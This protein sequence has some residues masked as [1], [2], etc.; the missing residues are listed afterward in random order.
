MWVKFVFSFLGGYQLH[1][2]PR[3]STIPAWDLNVD[4][5]SRCDCEVL[6]GAAV[7][8]GGS[9]EP[10]HGAGLWKAAASSSKTILSSRCAAGWTFSFDTA[11][12]AGH[13]LDFVIVVFFQKWNRHLRT[14]CM[15]ISLI[16][17]IFVRRQ[18]YKCS[19]LE[20]QVHLVQLL[21]IH[22]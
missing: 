10:Q 7:D 4:I 1:R 18:W 8:E 15:H 20:L 17:T 16:A 13:P 14:W 19:Y 21:Q 22:F 11:Y 5:N 9:L 2:H 3:V 12:P 6:P